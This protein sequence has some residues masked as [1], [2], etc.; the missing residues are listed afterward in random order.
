[1][2]SLHALVEQARADGWVA[3]V[4]T[5]DSARYQAS[6]LGWTLVASRRGGP[7]TEVLTPHGPEE[8]PKQS[9]SATYGL[10]AQPLHTDGAHHRTPPDLVLLSVEEPSA[11][12]TMLWRLPDTG[13][14]SE[15][16]QD[17]RHGLFT[18]RSGNE[19]FLA[20]ALERGRVR[21]DPGCMTAGD[22]RARRVTD[23]FG[24]MSEEATQHDWS[25]SGVVLAIDNR[26]VLHARA[27]A[28][29]EPTRSMHRV[30][31]RIPKEKE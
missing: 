28:E 25:S 18:V 5:L 23:F 27:S 17:L 2:L 16:S 31:I 7:K 24:S 22:A 9:L 8:A 19:A 13:F 3:V 10:G 14:G 11:V 29:S 1:M 12:P 26:S 30:A 15:I 20:P 4:G 21:Y 6:L